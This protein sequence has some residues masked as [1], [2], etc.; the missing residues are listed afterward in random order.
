MDDEGEDL[1]GEMRGTLP[2]K[3][4]NI[5]FTGLYLR[6]LPVDIFM[7]C[8][9]LVPLAPCPTPSHP[10]TA[11]SACRQGVRTSRFLFTLRNTSVDSLPRGMWEQMDHVRNLTLDLRNNS[12]KHLG[13]PNMASR[14]DQRGMFLTRLQMAGNRWS[15]DCDLG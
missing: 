5:T 3:L 4:F 1:D 2:D 10:L 13:N 15:C 9:L 14:P 8:R 6:S 7:V 12:L 11:V